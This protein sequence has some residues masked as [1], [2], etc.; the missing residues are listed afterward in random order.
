[1]RKLFLAGTAM[2]LAGV[3]AAGAAD[4]LPPVYAEPPVYET[5]VQTVSAAGGWYLR[6]DVG[7]SWN[8]MR[9]VNFFQGGLGTYSSFQTASLRSSYSIGGG[10]GYQI[11]NMLRTDVTLDYFSKADFRGSTTGSCGVAV[12]CT[13]TDLA[14]VT[15]LSLLANAYVDLYKKG[16]FT[17]YAGG[18]IGGTHLNWSNLSNTSCS[19]ANPALC[20]PTQSHGGA[21]GWRFTYALMAGASIDVTCNVKADVGY[22]FRHIAGGGMFKS[23]T[24]NGYQ[25]YHKSIKSHEVRGGLRYG[26]GGC[27]EQE[28]YIEPAP[29]MPVVYK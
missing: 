15:G 21:A 24:S 10:V 25:G 26:F 22:R 11:N 12:A 18:G 16:R 23:L 3:G 13:S 14:S 1:M 17:F 29:I 6:G 20:D 5:P 9:G 2:L 4:V 28:V 19:D 8:K 7:Y 27:A